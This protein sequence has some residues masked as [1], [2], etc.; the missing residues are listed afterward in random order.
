MTEYRKGRWCK[1]CLAD[2]IKIPAMHKIVKFGKEVPV[3]NKHWYTE[4]GKVNNMKRQ[5]FNNNLIQDVPI[6]HK[7]IRQEKI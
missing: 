2:H 1:L 6:W 5:V 4:R 3:C 7:S